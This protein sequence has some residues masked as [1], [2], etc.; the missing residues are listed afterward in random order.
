MPLRHEID[1]GV[2]APLRQ[3]ALTLPAARSAAL[4]AW[5][6]QV[7]SWTWQ[8]YRD[9]GRGGVDVWGVRWK[10]IKPE[11]VY[12]RLGRL[13]KYRSAGDKARASMRA[14]AWA[15]HEIGVDTG[16]LVNSLQF[17]R[18]G[19]LTVKGSATITVGTV[20]EY[21]VYFDKVRPI[22]PTD[23]TKAQKDEL[24]NLLLDEIVKR[25]SA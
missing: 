9:K 2:V 20:V 24:A 6:V 21:A 11:T 18:P 17:G 23:L 19:N 10:P 3:A 15:K 12:A 25:W 1:T 4:S 14:A 7:L 5:G 8:A 22:F 13:A 16:R